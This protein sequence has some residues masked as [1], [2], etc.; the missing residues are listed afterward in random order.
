MKSFIVQKGIEV[1]HNETNIVFSL[2]SMDD[3]VSNN[4]LSSRLNSIS[5]II[6]AVALIVHLILVH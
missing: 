5:T 4:T 6:I 2:G 3:R 1:E